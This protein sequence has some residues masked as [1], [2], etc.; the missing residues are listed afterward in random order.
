MK[1]LDHGPVFIKVELIFTLEGTYHS[2]VVMKMYRHLP[3]IEFSYRVTGQKIRPFWS[4]L[5][6]LRYFTWGRWNPIRSFCA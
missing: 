4:I 2:S 6:T 3:K 5:L 1:I